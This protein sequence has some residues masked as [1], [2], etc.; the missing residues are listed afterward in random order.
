[1]LTATLSVHGEAFIGLDRVQ[2]LEKPG[3][4]DMAVA[5]L[6]SAP[7]FE[8][9]DKAVTV[10]IA[11]QG[12]RKQMV[13]YVDTVVED[14][15]RGRDGWHA[16]VLGGTVPLRS[17]Q[18]RIWENRK[19]IDIAREI[20]Q[21]HGLAL[22]YDAYPY[23]LPFFAQTEQS[24]W[25]TLRA[26]AKETGMFLYNDNTVVRFVNPCREVKRQARLPLTRFRIGGQWEPSPVQSWGEIRS[27]SPVGYEHREYFGVDAFGK[28][29]TASAPTTSKVV[30]P[31]AE[32]VESLGEALAAVDRVKARRYMENRAA[33]VVAG[34]PQV[35][36]GNCV[37]VEDGNTSSVWMVSDSTHEADCTVENLHYVT[38]MTL[39]RANPTYADVVTPYRDLSDRPGSV[40]VNG[41]WRS[42]RAWVVE[43]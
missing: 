20:V 5:T 3:D 1:M 15:V 7:T 8:M 43:L 35:R 24:D 38:E 16:F 32:R 37:V 17:G 9:R 25:T 28:T 6:T 14:T 34:T 23:R 18:P 27:H 40:L 33:A 10:D 22:E 39:C 36:A 11:Y 4:H 30:L 13:G 12:R 26:L 29:F 41:K 21:R 31:A 42:Q 19:P 2:I